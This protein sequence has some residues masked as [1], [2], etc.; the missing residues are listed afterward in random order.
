MTT[1]YKI[2]ER[3]KY[4]VWVR[5]EQA[6]AHKRISFSTHQPNKYGTVVETNQFEMFIKP[7]EFDNFVE[8]LLAQQ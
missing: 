4:A 2:L 1:E 5:I 8:V 3:D 7:H 6:D